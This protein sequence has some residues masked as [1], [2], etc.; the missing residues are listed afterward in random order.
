MISGEEEKHSLL[1]PADIFSLKIE[2][3]TRETQPKADGS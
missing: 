1:R 2:M 3:G